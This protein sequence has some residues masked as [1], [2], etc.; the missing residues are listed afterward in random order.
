MAREEKVC[1]K[2]KLARM[3]ADFVR[4][5]PNPSAPHHSLRSLPPAPGLGH[6]GTCS[7]ERKSLQEICE[8]IRTDDSLFTMFRLNPEP[9]T[10]PFN[11]APYTFTYN[12][13]D[14]ECNSPVSVAESCTDPSKLLLKYQACPDIEDSESITEE[15]QCLALWKD[16]RNKYLV[17]TLKLFGRSAATNEETFRCF[18]YER[19]HHGEKVTY[20]IAQSGD[21][22]CSALND[23]SQGSRTIKLTKVDR[24]HNKCK[25]PQWVTKHHAWHSLDGTRAYHFTTG[26][27]TLKVEQ[28]KDQQNKGHK[29]EERIVCHNLESIDSPDKK[30]KLVAHITSGCDIGYVCMIFHRRSAGVIELQ[31]SNVKTILPE[32][33][34]K[35]QEDLS[36]MPYIT[37]ITSTLEKKR[38]PQPGRYHVVNYGSSHALS[39][40][41]RRQRKDTNIQIRDTPSSSSSSLSSSVSSSISQRA[42]EKRTWEEKND[43][44]QCSVSDIQ[45]GCTTSDQSE[46]I[47]INT[48]EDKHEAY[49]CHDS[50]EEKGV[51]YTIVS[52]KQKSLSGISINVNSGSSIGSESAVTNA[53]F[54]FSMRW[55]DPTPKLSGRGSRVEQEQELRL[56]WPVREFQ[57]DDPNQWTYK[58]SNQGVC[59]DIT[60]A[61]AT[62]AS[63]FS[64][65]SLV[66]SA[67]AAIICELLSR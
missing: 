19:N 39:I 28:S 43:D 29:Y 26:N 42:A 61:S 58:L 55:V 38:C 32:E 5:A 31:Q 12:R 11:G 60:R 17:G 51:W 16:G 2:Y 23:V 22:T 27:A 40:P 21:S 36:V 13:G 14:K 25:Y 66:L 44:E 67:G 54:C 18:L 59:E 34:C 62:S 56:T 10:C 9:I 52:Q 48:C 65:V 33:A 20:D 64:R 35:Q 47:I 45:I 24:E 37:L 50:W 46:M 63:S 7:S 4:F 53:S 3:F 30:V 6:L 49:T 57:R 15:L 8:S 41:S 1:P